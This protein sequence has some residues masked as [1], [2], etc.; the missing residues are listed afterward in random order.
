MERER[1]GPD[2]IAPSGPELIDFGI[3]EQQKAR[4]SLKAGRWKD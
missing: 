3:P 2:P 4:K 1:Q